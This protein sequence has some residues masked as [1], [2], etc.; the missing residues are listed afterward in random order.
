[1]GSLESDNDGILSSSF[2]VSSKPLHSFSKVMID[3]L[4]CPSG[5]AAEVSRAEA[6]K[7][8]GL[9]VAEITAA[10]QLKDGRG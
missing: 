9:L 10:A 8:C 5:N 4:V 7:L 1:M 6:A 3:A 2:G